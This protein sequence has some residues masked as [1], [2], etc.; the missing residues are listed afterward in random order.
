MDTKDIDILDTDVG[1]AKFESILDKDAPDGMNSFAFPEGGGWTAVYIPYVGCEWFCED[2]QTKAQAVL[3]LTRNDLSPEE[4][5][6]DFAPDTKGVFKDEPSPVK[7]SKVWMVTVHETTA[8]TVYVE[9]D[10]LEEARSAVAEDLDKAFTEQTCDWATRLVE[11]EV[12]NVSVYEGDPADSDMD[13]E[14]DEE[15]D[16]TVKD[17]RLSNPS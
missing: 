6:K 12:Q 10:T 2:F 5:R 16:F 13:Y 1:K 8:A 17:G 11:G 15:P 4:I 3:Y 7:K 9:A 14:S